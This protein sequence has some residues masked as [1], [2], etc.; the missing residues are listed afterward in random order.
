MVSNIISDPVADWCSQMKF[1]TV[2]L[3]KKLL[4]VDWI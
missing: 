2:E 1:D 4:N 3:Q